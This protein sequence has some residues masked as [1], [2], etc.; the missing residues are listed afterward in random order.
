MTSCESNAEHSQGVAIG[1]LGLREGLDRGVPL[2]DE[3][4]HL[5]SSDAD[6][7]EVGEAVESLDFLNLELDD[8]P[9]EIV[10][11]LL[12][13]IGVGDLEDTATEGVGGDV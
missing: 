1:G 13:E 7:G 4:A 3:G 5:V 9:G 8:S 12:V 10:L 11:V 6:T 2:L